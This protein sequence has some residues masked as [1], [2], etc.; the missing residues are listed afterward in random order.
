MGTSTERLRNPAVGRPGE[1]MMGRS[2]NACETSVKY[3]F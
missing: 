3:A 1:Q 2:R